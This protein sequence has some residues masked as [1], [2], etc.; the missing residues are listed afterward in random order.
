MKVAVEYI[1][2]EQA[3]YM[4]K[5]NPNNRKLQKSRVEKM[6]LFMERGAWQNNGSSIVMN[7]EVLLDGQHRLSAVVM[8][9][10]TIPFVVVRDVEKTAF[11]SIDTGRSRTLADALHVK[12]NRNANAVAAALN[13]YRNMRQAA[14]PRPNPKSVEPMTHGELIALLDECPH[15]QQSVQY[16]LDFEIRPTVS[17]SL[18]AALHALF[19]EKDR[20]LADRYIRAIGTGIG[21]QEGSVE[22]AVMFRLGGKFTRKS[23]KTNTNAQA[24]AIIKGW[25]HL[26]TGTIPQRI[27]AFGKKKTGKIVPI[28]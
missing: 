21:V 16:V 2:P 18:L 23:E 27:Q 26:R 4:L 1:T 10:M 20:R 14:V 5:H 7:G 22:A 24:I 13:F 3:T 8:S 11:S 15:I 19:S 28:E 9:G 12:G 17:V 6:A 25:N